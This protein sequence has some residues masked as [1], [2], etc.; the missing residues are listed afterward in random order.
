MKVNTYKET[1]HD[2]SVSY[3]VI[4]VA[5]PPGAGKHAKTVKQVL[6]REFCSALARKL[7]RNGVR[8]AQAQAREFV[9]GNVYKK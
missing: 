9:Y 2:G 4:R 8:N 6:R 1:I 7:K 3:S 5:I